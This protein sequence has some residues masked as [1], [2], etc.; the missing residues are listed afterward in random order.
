MNQEEKNNDLEIEVLETK[1]K[2]LEK[3][4]SPKI[5]NLIKVGTVNVYNQVLKEPLAYRYQKFYQAKKWHLWLDLLFA[6]LILVLLIFNI[7]LATD[8]NLYLSIDVGNVPVLKIEKNNSP[9][10]IDLNIKQELLQ[11]QSLVISQNEDVWLRINCENKG[12]TDLADLS[13][14]TDLSGL[15]LEYQLISGSLSQPLS[16]LKA[17]EKFQTE[18]RFKYLKSQQNTLKIQSELSLNNQSKINSEIIS[19]RINSDLALTAQARYFTN[20]GDQLGLGPLPPKIGQPTAYRIF[21]QLDNSLNNLKD[22]EVSG[23]L[24][25]NVSYLEESNVT[26]GRPIVYDSVTR[27]VAWKINQMEKGQ[28]TAQAS[29]KVEIIPSAMQFR[30]YPALIKDLNLKASDLFTGNTLEFKGNNVTTNL[31]NDSFA[32]NL[33]LVEK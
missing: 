22:I 1:S 13:L 11:P 31:Q 25:D 2:E 12:L 16:I 3:S 20:E 8:K 33:G 9:Q 15:G 17:G 19:L 7:I 28:T 26:L 27:K 21:W 10:K 5:V 32:K 30:T 18:I 6:L 24:P 14:T 23:F 4:K 29:F